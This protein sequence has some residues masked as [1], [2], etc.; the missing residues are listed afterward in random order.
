[1]STPVRRRLLRDFKRL[2]EDPPIGVSG[3]PSDNNILIWNAVIL[4]P[5]GTPFENGIFRLKLLFSETYPN[6]PPLV[7][8]RN[9]MFHPNIYANGIVCLD[10]LHSKWS[11]TY[12]IS[13]ILTSIRYLLCEP[14]PESPANSVA[15]STYKENRE[16]YDK[17]VKMC[18]EQTLI[19]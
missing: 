14:N 11:G 10:I 17:Q 1:M 3:A 4:G 9:R 7:R 18:V 15:A 6:E 2:Q 19:D 5:L 13:T 16:E 8:F 12:D